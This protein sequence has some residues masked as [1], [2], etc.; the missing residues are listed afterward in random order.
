[1]K[2]NRISFV[3]NKDNGYGLIEWP[4]K[5]PFWACKK[6]DDKGNSKIFVATLTGNPTIYLLETH[7][8]RE[9]D[10]NSFTPGILISQVSQ[11]SDFF[12][13]L[14]ILT[15]FGKTS[16]R[17]QQSLYPKT[18]V[19]QFKDKF[20]KWIRHFQIALAAVENSFFRDLIALCSLSVAALLPAAGNTIRNWIIK[21]FD[22]KKEEI[23]RELHA[24]S[25]S[26]F[27]IFFDLWTAP[28]MIPLIAM[29]V[30]YTDSFYK[31][32][33]MLIAVKR[34]KRN[35]SGENMA[36]FLIQI[37][38]EFDLDKRL[39]YFITDNASSNDVCIHFTLKISFPTLLT[40]IDHNAAYAI[41][42][43]SLISPAWR[44]FTVM[45][46]NHSKPS[47]WSTKYWCEKRKISR[48]GGNLVHLA[49][50]ITRSCGLG[51]I[52]NGG[53]CSYLSLNL[54]II[55][56]GLYQ[57]KIISHAGIRFSCQSRGLL[58]NRNR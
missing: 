54:T 33:T 2:R 58:K 44:T 13:F 36:A 9:H 21:A 20:L 30:H 56:Q 3:Y 51:V 12:I 45:K 15:L 23:K 7:G 1:M 4:S 31:N 18:L 19:D 24:E 22:E 27:H 57:F 43:A 46:P 11:S 48:H 28:N 38:R 40:P 42:A 26:L 41:T 6:C 5:K 37:L 32:R 47:T 34:L 50:Y 17:F 35:H 25:L 53:L 55:I 14:T 29:V 8:V 52:I 10:N 39:G 16:K 49:S